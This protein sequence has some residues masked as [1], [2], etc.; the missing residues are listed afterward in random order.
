VDPA[1]ELTRPHFGTAALVTIDVQRDTL[2]GEPLEVPGTSAVVPAIA[3]LCDSFRQAGRPIIHVVRLYLGDGSNAELSRRSLV[4]GPLPILRPG[5]PGRSLA[6][7][8]A[9]D[10]V[11]L[12][13]AL[14]LTGEI[15]TL[16][17]L[18]W[19]M[20]KPRWGAFFGTRL[21]E[22]LAT[23]GVDSLAFAG[24]NFPNCPR[25][26]I[27]EASER[28]YRVAVAEDAVSGLYHQG[29]HELENIGVHLMSTDAIADA[30][31]DARSR[32]ETVA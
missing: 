20:F 28:D 6:Q 23:L 4:S 21:H 8:V 26:S 11:E 22:H 17:P 15:Q 25:T 31:I 7:G 10:D 32:P 2:D 1:R 16:G 9:P 14:L 3:R 29:R 18:E 27:Y 24:C 30:V 12:D 19:A 13:D 5:T